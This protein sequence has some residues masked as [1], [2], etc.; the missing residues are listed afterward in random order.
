VE[1]GF[2]VADLSASDST[3]GASAFATANLTVAAVRR[4]LFKVCHH[5]GMHRCHLRLEVADHSFGF[6]VCGFFFRLRYE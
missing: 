4:L 5:F 1:V 3:L 2:G 6:V